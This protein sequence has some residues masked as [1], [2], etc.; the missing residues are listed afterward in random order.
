MTL[1]GHCRLILYLLHSQG[2]P[3]TTTNI[4]SKSLWKE[5]CIFKTNKWTRTSLVVKTSLSKE[6]DVDLMPNWETKIPRAAWPKNQN[7]KQKRY[8][9]KFNTRF[10]FKMVHIKKKKIFKK[11][12]ETKGD[13]PALGPCHEHHQVNTPLL[14]VFPPTEPTAPSPSRQLPRK[15]AQNDPLVWERW[16]SLEENGADFQI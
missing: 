9:S 8:C 1:C 7:I 13:S 15:T 5:T 10:S 3:D 2:N 4:K 16:S 6:G 12:K 11:C 14:P